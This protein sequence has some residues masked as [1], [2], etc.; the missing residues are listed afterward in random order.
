MRL[1][2]LIAIINFKVI[3]YFNLITKFMIISLNLFAD[4]MTKSDFKKI[5]IKDLNF[6]NF[7]ISIIAAC[8][9]FKK[10]IKVKAN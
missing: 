7:I 8:L 5:I 10:T 6:I 9:M 2:D 1:S 4:F 3:K